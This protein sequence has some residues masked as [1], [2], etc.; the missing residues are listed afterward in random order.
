MV[1]SAISLMQD[2][3]HKFVALDGLRGVAA[4]AVVICHYSK[5]IGTWLFSAA[6][7]V[8]FFF[9]LSGFVISYAYEERLR[10][11]LSYWKFMQIRLIRLY[12]LYAI[13]IVIPLAAVFTNAAIGLPHVSQS[14]AIISSM[15][16]SLLLPVPLAY[17]A[18]SVIVFPINEPAWSLSL[19]LAI[20]ALYVFFCLRLSTRLLGA[21][22]LFSAIWLAA[23]CHYFAE[24]LNTGWAWGNY[25]G[26]WARV[27]WGFP[28]GILLF[29][30]YQSNPAQKYPSVIAALLPMALIF[31]FSTAND[32]NLLILVWPLI[33]FPA[34][35][36]LGARLEIKGLANALCA[37]LGQISYSL[38]ITHIGTLQFIVIVY[39]LLGIDPSVHLRLNT[40]FWTIIA[41]AFAWLLD[42]QY[43][44]KVRRY[45]TAK[46]SSKRLAS[47]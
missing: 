36:W 43:D 6:I 17:S 22:C 16:N 2:G 9:I 7:A 3:K 26:G 46:F 5:E 18:D 32:Q 10:Q 27:L 23:S 33:L 38:Y 35:I 4:I 25:L 14:L 44:K 47:L 41:V 42:A 13:G 24:G 34:C 40:L 29:R 45:L 21:V 15:F 8:D 20:N 37:W 19:E 1:R 30:L 12:P 28:A 39:K 11:G 31:A